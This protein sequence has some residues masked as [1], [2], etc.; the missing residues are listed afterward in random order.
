MGSMRR[1]AVV[2]L[3][4]VAQGLAACERA[5]SPTWPS[6]A[7]PRAAVSGG[8]R[9][10]SSSSQISMTVS[11]VLGSA[12]GTMTVNGHTLAVPA[13]ALAQPT[14]FT[15]STL[16]GTSIRVSLSA[17]DARTGAAVT[18]FP[19]PLRLGL[20]YANAKAS[21]PNQLKVA[22]LVDGS[23]VAVQPSELDKSHKQVVSTLHHFS[24]WGLIT[25]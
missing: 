14:R 11:V 17:R 3:A 23:I 6:A 24:D 9:L 1:Y 21:S 22:W 19:T 13:G 12:G 18:V 7:A 15:M 25:D 5:E 10:V 4:L 2:G 20:S 16:S 8:Y